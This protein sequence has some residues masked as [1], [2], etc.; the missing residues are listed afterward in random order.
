MKTIVFALTFVLLPGWAAAQDQPKPKK[1]V[2]E[3]RK[4]AQA[5]Q[6]PCAE[7]GPGFV[8][9]AGTNTCVKIGGSVEV[10]GQR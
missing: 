3:T 5:T 9:V 6:K 8:Q 4:P 7:F 1:P 2:P 10:G